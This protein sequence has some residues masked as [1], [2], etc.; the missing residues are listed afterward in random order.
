MKAILAPA[1]LLLSAAAPTVQASD[2]WIPDFDKA[3]ELAKAQKKD[4]LVD[5]TGSDW[6]GWCTRLDKE[7]FGLPEFTT[8]AEKSFVLVALDYP[9]KEENKAKVPNPTRNEELR[10]KHDVRGFPTVLLMNVD[11]EVFASTGYQAGGVDAYLVHLEEV[12]SAG[13]KTLGE[14]KTLVADFTKAKDAEKIA[15]LEKVIARMEGLEEGSP[16]AATLAGP[17]R[18]ALTLDPKNER[19]L[20]VR[21]IK[22]LLSSGNGDDELLATAREL[23][24]KNEHGLLERI[25][26]ASF[27]KVRDDE[28]AKAA[29]VELDSLMALGFKDKELGFRLC[30]HAA[31]WCAGP[32]EDEALSKKYA[33]AAKELGPPDE[34][35]A[36]MLDEMIGEE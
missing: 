33:R 7:V 25:V 18:E 2:E 24:P 17:V 1:L 15:Q 13:R 3:L 16:F 31:R 19:G 36:K 21:A 28:S 27:S 29:L 22:A 8:V 5:F 20:K 10:K 32:L 34:E 11:G 35:V 4:L 14:I 30:F 6:C 23:D 26:D 12:A 9:S